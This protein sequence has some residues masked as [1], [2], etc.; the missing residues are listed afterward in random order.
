MLDQK[1]ATAAEV[2]RD[3]ERARHGSPRV[4]IRIALKDLLGRKLRL[5][6]TS[7]AIVMGVAMVSGTFVLT[8]T[9]NA[10]FS[11]IFSTAYSSSDAVVTGQGGLRRLAERAVVPRVDA[12][13]DPGAARRRRG[14]RRDR[15]PGAVRRL[16]RQGRRRHG[17]APGLAFS[18]NGPTALQPAHAR[19]GHAGRTGRTRSAST[20]T[21]PRAS[22]SRSVRRSCGRPARRARSRRSSSAAIVQLRELD[23]ARRRDAR[24]LRPADRAGALP[25][26]GPAR[27]DRRRGEAGRLELERSS[28]EIQKVLPPNT[29][30]RTG[31]G[32]GEAEHE[33]DERPARVPALLPA[34]LRRRSRSSSAR[35]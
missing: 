13:P 28:S 21:R 30:V 19:R 2:L 17:G 18:T 9:I 11:S 4:V 31:A 5:I 10:G 26:G 12:R 15:R 27:P 20:S 6:L 25:Q 24:D 1:G 35:S 22:T 16:E 7:L 14:R 29:Q 23:L 32:P 3:D 34:R 8:D 33:G